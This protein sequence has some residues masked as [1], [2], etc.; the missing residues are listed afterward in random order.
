ML[1]Q[2]VEI[3]YLPTKDKTNLFA[4]HLKG[5]AEIVTMRKM[6]ELSP[7]YVWTNLHMY[8]LAEIDLTTLKW[9]IDD[10]NIV[11]KAV[12]LDEVYWNKRQSYKQ[13][14]ATTD[15]SL[16][17]SHIPLRY[18]QEYVMAKIKP[19]HVTIEMEEYMT[20]GW[21]PTYNNPDNAN[22]ETSA[23]IA[24]RPKTRNQNIIIV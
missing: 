22:L 12:I 13:I 9:Y 10:T 7:S 1:T 3:L 20:E 2:Q 14:L 4:G 6:V 8:F 17:L 11:R 19:T 23:E 16:E 5:K 15:S 21:V 24:L 18:L